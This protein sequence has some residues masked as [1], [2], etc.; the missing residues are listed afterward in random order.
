MTAEGVDPCPDC[1]AQVIGSHLQHEPT[2]PAS[3]ALDA[4]TD[5]DG[6]WF[7]EHPHATYRYRPV[8]SAEIIEHEHAT[9][10]RLP[11]NTKVRVT[12][13]APGVRF[14]EF[15]TAVTP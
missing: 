9:G 12:Q 11:A 6:D 13:V 4:V 14:R 7:A 1:A 3:A 2:C 15:F 10:V 5:A 8:S